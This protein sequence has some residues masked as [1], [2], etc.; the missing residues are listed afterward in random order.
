[1]RNRGTPLLLVCQSHGIS[2]F[3]VSY[4]LT[5][6]LPYDLAVPFLGTE[7]REMEVYIDSNTYSFNFKKMNQD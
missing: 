7:P 4:A 2:H 5:M 6:N 1:M 3:M